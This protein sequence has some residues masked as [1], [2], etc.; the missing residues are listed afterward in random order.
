M[1]RWSKV[2]RVNSP[3]SNQ[4]VYLTCTYGHVPYI[5][6]RVV[7]TQKRFNNNSCRTTANQVCVGMV[8]Y[9]EI[10]LKRNHTGQRN[11]LQA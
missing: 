8:T 3:H 11:T 2:D 6:Q 7:K 9:N 5:R 1:A 10:N 4:H